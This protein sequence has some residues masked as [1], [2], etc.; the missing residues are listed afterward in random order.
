[1]DT[2]HACKN[3]KHTQNFREKTLKDE[4]ALENSHKWDDNIK[5]N[6]GDNRM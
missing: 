6:F 2:K 3:D 1:L 4:N 5:M